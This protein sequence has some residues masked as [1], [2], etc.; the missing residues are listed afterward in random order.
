VA[1]AASTALPPRLRIAIPA[2][3]ACSLSATTNPV[4][5]SNVRPDASVA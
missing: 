4:V 5:D 1:I 2:S 3:L